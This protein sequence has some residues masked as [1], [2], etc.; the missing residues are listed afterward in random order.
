MSLLSALLLLPFFFIISFSAEYNTS[1]FP[2]CGSSNCGGVNISY[3]FWKI[4]SESTT[5]FCGYEGFGINCSQQNISEI[6][7]NGD[8]YYVESINYELGTIL[9]AD[10]E[11]SRV[12]EV[13]N[14]CPRVQHNI[15]LGTLPF[16]FAMY[17]IN[18]SFHFDCDRCPSFATEVPCLERDN[19]KACL[20]IV[21]NIIDELDWNEYSCDQEVITTVS[22]GNLERFP[23]LPTSFSSI[24][25]RGFGLQWKQTDDC[26]KC[27]ESNG[28]CG[29][30][31][32]VGFLCYCADGTTRKG[33]C[34]GTLVT[35]HVL[36]LMIVK[37]T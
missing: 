1:T 37:I 30:R 13:W 11:V 7:F 34:K 25:E 10:Y 16:D 6:T 23:D 28:R 21:N 15:T 14:N 4:D 26:S 3:P 5:Q 2:E 35:S 9:L 8:S 17:T 24:L 22:G 32:T 27:E 19:G 12:A 33:D 36:L 20:D 18:L 31:N 29:W